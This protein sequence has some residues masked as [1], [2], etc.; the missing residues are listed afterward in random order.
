MATS[1][2]GTTAKN[3]AMVGCAET[4]GKPKYFAIWGGSLDAS[5]QA[6]AATICAAFL[7]DSELSKTASAKLFPLP[8]RQN[9]EVTKGNAVTQSFSNGIEIQ[10][11]D[12]L[13]TYKLNF[14]TTLQQMKALY[15]FNQK[16]LRFI[17]QDDGLKVWG[18][19]DAS[20]NFIGAQGIMTVDMLDFKPDDQLNNIGSVS[21][22][23]TDLYELKEGR[24]YVAPGKSLPSTTTDMLDVQL[25]EKGAAASNALKVSAKIDIA[26]AG[27]FVDLYADY[28]A[29]LFNTASLWT[30][31]NVTTGA[32]FTITS[33]ASNAAGYGVLTLDS[34]LHT[35][36]PSGGKVEISTVLPP[37]LKV[38]GVTGIETISFIYTKP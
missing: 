28:S 32:A 13:P 20:S 30:A 24:Y 35:A 3:T 31:K 21:I 11:R 10:V 26:E 9:M 36:L 38:G 5:E 8:V 17:I 23:L 19:L 12:G 34:T 15:A 4:P 29:T 7:A 16:S 27:K 18:T 33:L 37:A 14:Y 6:T 1:V 2:C 22:T 25:Y